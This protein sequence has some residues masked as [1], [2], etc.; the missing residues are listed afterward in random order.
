MIEVER[1]ADEIDRAYREGFW[2][3]GPVGEL[4]NSLSAREALA[5]PIPNAHSAWE[6]ALHID[7]WHDIFR[8]RIRNEDMAKAM[9]FDW[10]EPSGTTN[11]DWRDAL[12]KLEHGLNELVEAVKTLDDERLDSKVSGREFTFYEM[13]HGVAQHDLYHA[14]QVLMLKKVIHDA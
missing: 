6:I 13:L 1:I 2:G 11:A 9:E 12:T 14:G 3:G 8:G 4:F 7:V 5:Y 10:P